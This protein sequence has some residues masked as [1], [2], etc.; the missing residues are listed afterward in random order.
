ML[1]SSGP[2]A[3]S[4][5]GISGVAIPAA[6]DGVEVRYRWPRDYKLGGIDFC[7]RSGNQVQLANTRLRLADARRGSLELVTSGTGQD[8]LRSI[9]GL[10]MR[11]IVPMGRTFGGRFQAF[12]RV[13]RTGDIWIIQV[14]NDN[15]A[16]AIV[17]EL[18]F[19]LEDAPP[20]Q[21][22]S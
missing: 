7:I 4:I 14:F 17:P 10:L 11:G 20:M 6:S 3:I 13:V 22:A 18:F 19:R 15:A 12:Q 21:E 2:I 16:I 8:A 1:P 9:N 5:P